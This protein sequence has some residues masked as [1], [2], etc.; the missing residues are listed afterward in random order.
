MISKPT[1]MTPNEET[2]SIQNNNLHFSIQLQSGSSIE[3]WV[4]SNG[5]T[6]AYASLIILYND[7]YY[8]FI[9]DEFQ[10]ADYAPVVI[11]GTNG[12]SVVLDLPLN[13]SITGTY[14][15]YS[16]NYSNSR[17]VWYYNIGSRT[18]DSLSDIIATGRQYSWKLRLYDKGSIKDDV[19]YA[20]YNKIAYGTIGK[21]AVVYD[22]W[23]KSSSDRIATSFSYEVFPHNNIYD[24]VVGLFSDEENKGTDTKGNDV[25]DGYGNDNTRYKHIS[26]NV[27]NVIKNKDKHIK[28]WIVCNGSIIPIQKYRFYPYQFDTYGHESYNKSLNYITQFDSYGNPLSGYVIV[29]REYEGLEKQTYEIRTNYIDSKW[30]YFEIYDPATIT[31]TDNVGNIIT[32]NE[33]S[34]PYSSLE[35]NISFEQAQGISLN[36]Y[37]YKVYCYNESD[38]IWELDYSSGNFYNQAAQ[39]SYDR[40]FNQKHYKFVISMVDTKQNGYEREMYFFTN[41]PIDSANLSVSAGYYKEHNS[42]IVDFYNIN[43]MN[44]TSSVNGNKCAYYNISEPNADFSYD[45]TLVQGMPTDYDNIFNDSDLGLAGDKNIG[46]YIPSGS[47]IVWSENDFGVPF[48]WHNA[49]IVVDFYGTELTGVQNTELMHFSTS[50]G[51]EVSVR[52]VNGT[53]L[54]IITSNYSYYYRLYNS[55]PDRTFSDFM[56]SLADGNETKPYLYPMQWYEID[57]Y[58]GSEIVWKDEWIWEEFNNIAVKWRLI[59]TPY[60]CELL[61]LTEGY[62]TVCGEGKLLQKISATNISSITLNGDLIYDNLTIVN[63]I[64]S[65]LVNV[66]ENPTYTYW[67]W[68]SDTQFLC[69]FNGHVNGINSATTLKNLIGYRVYK[70]IGNNNKLYEIS[71]IEISEDDTNGFILEDFIVGDKC[72]Y[73]YYIYPICETKIQGNDGKEY[74]QRVITAPLVTEPVMINDGA[75]SIMGLT[76]IADKIYTVNIDEVWVFRYNLEDNGFILNTDKVFYDTF[77][78]YNQESVGN[79]KYITKSI[80]GLLGYINCTKG[81]EYV[82][83]YDMLIAWNNFSSSAN[84]KCLV[85]S[86]GLILPGNFESNPSVDY[87]QAQGNPA[88]VKFNWRQKSDLDIIKIYARILPCNPL[89][90]TYLKGRENCYLKSND[91]YILTANE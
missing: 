72:D 20:P 17:D 91:S 30:A 90:G 89:S 78:R 66:F 80:S 85:D 49:G 25:G 2:I 87:I 27:F 60:K 88:K 33:I 53:T 1:G 36:Y 24:D 48:N 7:I 76:E 34:L 59:I 5:T 74:V 40:F 57:P 13:E 54:Q 46:L 71:D 32:D 8:N 75:I 37:S 3:T 39:I 65:D 44:P 15:K 14:C 38:D 73:Q 45:K 50:D 42:V 61:C 18:L 21:R 11:Y 82:D 23:N 58:D 19:S 31:I 26:S 69:N 28:Y 9:F 83:N 52:Y 6:R 67:N 29:D 64:N 10:H 51:F 12:I 56:D 55:S 63:N 22:D 70:T 16:S 86:R 84:N 43:S 68:T 35:L 4:D 81:G 79:R 62:D 77:N 41:F 47:S